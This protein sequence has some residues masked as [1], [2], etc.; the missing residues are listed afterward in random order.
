MF[1]KMGRAFTSSVLVV[2]DC[3][4]VVNEACKV[5]SYSSDWGWKYPQEHGWSHSDEIEQNTNQLTDSTLLLTL[6]LWWLFVLVKP[7]VLVVNN[8]VFRVA[9][10]D[11]G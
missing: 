7:F 2:A 4:V 8:G 6:Y 3:F 1:I 10:S 11:S 5:A 9:Y